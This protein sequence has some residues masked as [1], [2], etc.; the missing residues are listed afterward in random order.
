MKCENLY[1]EFKKYEGQPVKIYTDDGKVHC[2]IELVAYDD[3]VKILD[4]CGRTIFIDYSHV[5]AVVE[6]MMRLDRCCRD[7]C[8][9]RGE[10][11]YG[12]FEGDGC[13]E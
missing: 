13:R 10:G 12:D 7:H 8:E 3:A 6:P 5:D 4:K 2:G 9:C 11:D 1:Q